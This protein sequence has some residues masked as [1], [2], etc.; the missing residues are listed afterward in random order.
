[1]IAERRSLFG[2]LALGTSIVLSALGQ[3]CMKAGMQ[4]LHFATDDSLSVAAPTWEA[5]EPAILWTTLGVSAYGLSLLSWL[6][7]LAR[8]PLSYAYPFLGLSY[9][10]V[11]IGAA[12]WQA[13]AEPVTLLKTLGTC[14]VI[15]GV[16]LL[17]TSG[18]NR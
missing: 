9:V 3:L 10:L 16:A 18:A 2:L 4:K 11:Y 17:S 15:A 1:M 7:V 6:V 13:L 12:Q 5:L 8:Y 14:F